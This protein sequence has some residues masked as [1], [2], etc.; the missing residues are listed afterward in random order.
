LIA[1]FKKAIK[2]KMRKKIF[3]IGLVII[4]LFVGLYAKKRIYDPRHRMELA[5]KEVELLTKQNEIKDGDIIF[6]TSL[7]NQSKAIQLATKSKYSHCG[8][9]F[10]NEN[11]FYVLEAV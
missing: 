9:I 5:K 7:S 4:V 2:G 1:A 6:Q 10:K 3:L 11:G 8:I